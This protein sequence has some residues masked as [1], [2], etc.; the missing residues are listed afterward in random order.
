MNKSGLFANLFVLAIVV[1]IFSKTTN[2]STV[3]RNFADSLKTGINLAGKFLGK[4]R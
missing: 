2:C 4:R 3:N 1:T